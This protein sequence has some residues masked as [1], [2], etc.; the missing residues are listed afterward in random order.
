MFTYTLIKS[1]HKY[2][3][4][5]IVVSQSN[6]YYSIYTVFCHPKLIHILFLQNIVL[7]FILLIKS[8]SLLAGNESLH[9]RPEM[10]ICIIVW[11]F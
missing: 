3:P 2:S 1:A 5:L 9:I 7:Y 10:A 8:I 11:L 6:K 4:K